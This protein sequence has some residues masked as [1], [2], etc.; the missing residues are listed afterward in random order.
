LEPTATYGDA[1]R[2][3]LERSGVPVYRAGANQTHLASEIYDGVPSWHDGKSAAVI[4]K[5]HLDG[6]T[7]L[8]RYESTARRDNR[9]WV[10]CHSLYHNALD[11][12]ARRLEQLLARH[13]P[14]LAEHLRPRSVSMLTLLERFGGPQGVAET[15]LAAVQLM[16]KASRWKLPDEAVAGVVASAKA[17]LGVPQTEGEVEHVR[18]LARE[19]MRLHEQ[20]RQAEKRLEKRVDTSESTALL[21]PVTGKRTAAILVGYL[22]ELTGY[23]SPAALEKAAG[24]NLKERSSGKKQGQLRLSKRGAPQVRKYVY[25]LSLRIIL[26]EP[27]IRGWYD[28]RTKRGIPKQKSITALMRKVIRALWYVA[29]GDTF[30]PE[31]LIDVRLVPELPVIRRRGFDGRPQTYMTRSLG[32]NLPD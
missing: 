24:L 29:R 15:P 28:D 6:S 26:W 11:A 17:T 14:E 8:W 25:L 22:G 7:T 1:L 18:E 4:A 30:D 31:K 21:A 27:V 13:W 9:A 10:A 19:L 20:A 12:H 16:G 3:Q 23:N 5:L 32:F 2:W